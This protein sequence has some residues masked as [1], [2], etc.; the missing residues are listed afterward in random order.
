MLVISILFIDFILLEML[1]AFF[2][3]ILSICRSNLLLKVGAAFQ[4]YRQMK[5]LS[6]Y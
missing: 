5:N 1:S 4:I 6:K 3:A 2:V